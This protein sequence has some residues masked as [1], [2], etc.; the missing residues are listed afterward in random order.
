M[1]QVQQ[2]ESSRHSSEPRHALTHTCTCCHPATAD[3]PSDAMLKKVFKGYC[4]LRLGQGRQTAGSVQQMNAAQF[5]RMCHDAG[6]SEPSGER[7]ASTLLCAAGLCTQ[8]ALTYLLCWPLAAR[9]MQQCNHW[10]QGQSSPCL[11]APGPARHATPHHTTPHHTTSQHTSHPAHHFAATLA[12]PSAGTYPCH[13]AATRRRAG[14]A[15]CR[16]RVCALQA[17]G[18]PPPGLQGLPGR[19]GRRGGGVGHG[20]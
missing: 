20:L 6:I 18:Q 2:C 8:H 17:P 3:A 19:A 11:A 7:A 9:A 13:L 12:Q 1:L 15:R 14:A 4:K 10:R 5:N 16:H